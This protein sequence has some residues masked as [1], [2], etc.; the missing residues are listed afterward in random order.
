MY[1]SEALGMYRIQ[2]KLC[3][4]FGPEAGLCVSQLA[5]GSAGTAQSCRFFWNCPVMQI[6]LTFLGLHIHRSVDS[7]Q[8][9]LL[10]YLSCPDSSWSTSFFALFQT[11]DELDTMNFPLS[12]ET[13]LA[14]P[15]P[16][17]R[18][19][20]GHDSD[21]TQL[22]P[23][24]PQGKDPAVWQR[25][26]RTNYFPSKYSQTH[27]ICFIYI[28]RLVAWNFFFPYIGKNNGN[29]LVFFGGAETTNQIHFYLL[30]EIA[31]NACQHLKTPPYPG[32]DGRHGRY[33]GFV[34]S[35]IWT[36]KWTSQ[37]IYTSR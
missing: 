26:L 4:V 17:K 8:I 13:T 36:Q 30:L 16:L 31:D 23:S 29:W 37:H 15:R 20:K 32:W 6:F 5:C 28:F 14:R 1:S 11:T 7:P 27:S 25:C 35:D 22:R 3:T 19:L 21:A 18:G 2:T 24:C 34:Q 12:L 33:G 9:W 10:V